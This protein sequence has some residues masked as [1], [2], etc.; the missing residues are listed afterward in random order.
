[1]HGCSEEAVL[2]GLTAPAVKSA[3][4]L[5]VS[6]Q[7][8]LFLDA[9]ADAEIVAVGPV[10][11]KQFVPLPYPTKSTTFPPLGQLVPEVISV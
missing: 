7:P 10:P 5:S 6:L 8:L 1:V 11:S 3:A 4:L 9:D 2:R